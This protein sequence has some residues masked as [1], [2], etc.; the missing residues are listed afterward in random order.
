M[1]KAYSFGGLFN[2]PED[3]NYAFMEFENF[4]VRE[5][6]I[7]DKSKGEYHIKILD[8]SNLANA[9]GFFRRELLGCEV[10][11]VDPSGVLHLEYPIYVVAKDEM[12]KSAM[13]A[14]FEQID[15]KVRKHKGGQP[16]EGGSDG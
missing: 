5:V 3:I 7:G 13:A 8:G 11:I 16:I 15:S 10:D 6:M 2:R 14:N 1:M 12:A 4:V 9:V